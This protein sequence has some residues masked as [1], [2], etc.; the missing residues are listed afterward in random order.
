VLN[1]QQ[2]M[3]TGG[4]I[5][6]EGENNIITTD[7]KFPLLAGNYI[8]ITIKDQGIGIP[9]EH[10]QNIFDPY[11]T[12]KQEG[13]GLGLASVYSIIRKHGGYI[14]AESEVGKGATLYLYLPAATEEPAAPVKEERDSFTGKGSVLVMD[15]EEII[16]DV[17]GAMLR[18]MGYSVEYARDGEEAV[19]Q[20]KRAQ[21]SGR[22]F[23]AVIM[24]LT[25][26]GGMGGKETIVRLH[27]I[28]PAVRAIVSSG[29]SNDP[30][31]AHYKEYGFAG[32]VVKPYRVQELS[33]VVYRVTRGL[34]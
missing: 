3:P 9:R 23:D 34:V 17:T 30:V 2:A 28:D 10:L 12:T 24:D 18:G 19:D 8:K 21:A 13:S 4:T 33:E 16:R 20:Y 5:E 11:F 6:I 31:M 1:A 25:I 26:P 32:M 15:D 27:E 22:P 14:A 7:D 29:Y